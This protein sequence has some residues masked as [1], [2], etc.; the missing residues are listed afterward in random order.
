MNEIYRRY[1]GLD[2]NDCAVIQRDE[3]DIF[4]GSNYESAPSES[5]LEILLILNLREDVNLSVLEHFRDRDSSFFPLT[6]LK[7][8]RHLEIDANDFSTLLFDLSQYVRFVLELFLKNK[9]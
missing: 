1:L 6:G 3:A 2:V 9:S 8:C 5:D 7:E 4:P